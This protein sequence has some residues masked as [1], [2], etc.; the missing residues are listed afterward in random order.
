MGSGTTGSSGTV[1][2]PLDTSMLSDA[3]DVG[4][5][6]P[7]AFNAIV[8]GF[9]SSGHVIWQREVITENAT[10]AATASVLTDPAT[11][12]PVVASGAPPQCSPT[13][14]VTAELIATHYRYVRLLAE[15]SSAGMSTQLAYTYN[16][17][18]ARQTVIDA[19]VSA[20]GASWGVGGGGKLRAGSFRG[21]GD[22][23]QPEHVE[24]RQHDRGRQVHGSPLHVLRR[25]GHVLVHSHPQ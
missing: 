21:V 22:G 20:N 23:Q 4:D 2:I 24:G 14:S 9:D 11:G 19:A 16:S 18:T 6:I 25:P 3:G 1:S 10:T 17:S 13:G 12:A 7:D 5:G 15:N 8:T